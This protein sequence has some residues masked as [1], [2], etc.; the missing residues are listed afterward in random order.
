VK[1]SCGITLCDLLKSKKKLTCYSAINLVAASQKNLISILQKWKTHFSWDETKNGIRGVPRHPKGHEH[2]RYG[3][4]SRNYAMIRAKPSSFDLKAMQPRMW[5]AIFV[6][7]LFGKL[8][9]TRFEFF[10]H[11]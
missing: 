9:L 8:L 6:K 3:F 5:Y 10:C 11:I 4:V 1:P 2:V 7:G